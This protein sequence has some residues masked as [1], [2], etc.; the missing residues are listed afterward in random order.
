MA[1][2]LKITI[3]T[4][5]NLVVVQD[6]D[7]ATGEIFQIIS[8]GMGEYT[9]QQTVNVDLT[10]AAA[11][12]TFIP[13]DGLPFGA[14]KAT[15]IESVTING[16]AATITNLSLVRDAVSPYFFKIGSGGYQFYKEITITSAML[17]ADLAIAA[18]PSNGGG[19]EIFPAV[20]NTYYDWKIDHELHYG[21]V[22]YTVASQSGFY[23]QLAGSASFAILVG[24]PTT[25]LNYAG[26]RVVPGIVPQ[27]TSSHVMPIYDIGERIVYKLANNLAQ[28]TGD[29]YVKLKV[30]YN[31]RTFG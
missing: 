22:A 19:I 1:R 11:M 18:L 8:S 25:A 7:T 4:A 15:D 9:M 3:T 6:Y 2:K 31:I 10:N 26:D 14:V 12:V 30:W 21:S 29:G 24:L 20:A 13:R 16:V 23:S 17:K 27:M 28:A 5:S